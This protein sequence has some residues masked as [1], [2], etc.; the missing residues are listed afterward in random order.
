MVL[1]RWLEVYAEG[2]SMCH[3]L[4]A[5]FLSKQR[6]LYNE[7]WCSNTIFTSPLANGLLFIGAKISTFLNSGYICPIYFLSVENWLFLGVLPLCRIVWGANPNVPMWAELKLFLKCAMENFLKPFWVG[8]SV[9][10][11]SGQVCV[12]LQRNCHCWSKVVRIA[13]E[14]KVW[15]FLVFVRWFARSSFRLAYNVKALPQ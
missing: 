11:K 2:D 9:S 4:Q 1:Q 15:S 3:I 7:N 14:V 6:L 8:L 12:G 10:E 13:R 5:H